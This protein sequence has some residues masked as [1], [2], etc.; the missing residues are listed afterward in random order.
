MNDKQAIAWS[1]ACLLFIA[2]AVTTAYILIP[3]NT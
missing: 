3:T 1:V 2:V